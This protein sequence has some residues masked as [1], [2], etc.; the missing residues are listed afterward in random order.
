MFRFYSARGI[1]ILTSLL[2]P[3]LYPML[4]LLRLIQPEKWSIMIRLVVKPYVFIHS[5][6]KIDI[7]VHS[8]VSLIWESA[9]TYNTSNPL[10]RIKYAKAGLDAIILYSLNWKETKIHRKSLVKRRLTEFDWMTKVI[11]RFILSLLFEG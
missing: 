9:K 5:Y 1:H 7:S 2:F 8:H 11:A 6:Q 3:L 10:I 4:W